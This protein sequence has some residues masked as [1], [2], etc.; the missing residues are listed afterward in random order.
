MGYAVRTEL[1]N[2]NRPPMDKVSAFQPESFFSSRRI[3]G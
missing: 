2:A 1:S 3:I